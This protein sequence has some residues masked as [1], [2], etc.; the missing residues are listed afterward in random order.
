MGAVMKLMP[1]VCLGF[2]GALLTAILIGFCIGMVFSLLGDSSTLF[3]VELG[4]IVISL[5]VFY[6]LARLLSKRQ[7]S[8]QPAYA[9]RLA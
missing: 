5:A 2:G 1:A 7:K 3:A 6:F 8:K 4:G 9:E